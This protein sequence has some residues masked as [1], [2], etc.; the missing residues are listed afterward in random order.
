MF[1]WSHAFILLGASDFLLISACRCKIRRRFS[2]ET[3]QSS[4]NLH[5]G[6]HF[7]SNPNDS[8]KEGLWSLLSHCCPPEAGGLNT[9][10]VPALRP[11]DP[12]LVVSLGK[13]LPADVLSVSCPGTL[14]LLRK[15]D[16]YFC[17]CCQVPS[18]DV[19][20]L[21]NWFPTWRSRTKMSLQ[22]NE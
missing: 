8:L 2:S 21:I 18:L 17:L 1:E 10:S 12:S 4:R 7:V 6:F 5:P 15:E 13:V 3:V 19:L 9:P 22:M 20:T 14:P 16:F 11:S